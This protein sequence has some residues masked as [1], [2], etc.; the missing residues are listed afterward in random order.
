MCFSGEH[1]SESVMQ[2]AQSVSLLSQECHIFSLYSDVY[3]T[4]IIHTFITSRQQQSVPN[5]PE[6]PVRCHH[7]TPTLFIF[8]ML[9]TFLKMYSPS[10]TIVQSHKNVS[11]RTG[12]VQEEVSNFSKNRIENIL[13]IIWIII[14]I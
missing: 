10:I 13:I 1:K 8:I 9:H 5:Q 7:S 12:S 4:V 3:A 2:G 14:E 11:S 6:P